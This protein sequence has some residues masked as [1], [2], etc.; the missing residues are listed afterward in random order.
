M[1][2]R[3]TQTTGMIVLFLFFFTILIILF[4]PVS[5]TKTMKLLAVSE[6]DNGYIGSTADLFLDVKPG[7]GRIFIDTYPLSKLDTQIST[8]FA[9]EIACKEIE[10]DCSEYDFFYT[11]KADT[12]IVGGPSAGSAISI[13]TIASMKNLELEKNIA[14]TGTIN[15]GGTIGPVGGLKEKIDAAVKANITK[16]LIPKGERIVRDDFAGNDSG[17]ATSTDLVEYAGKAGIEIVE[18]GELNEAV[19]LFSGRKIKPDFDSRPVVIDASYQNIMKNLAATLCS[20]TNDLFSEV[21]RYDIKND[22]VMAQKNMALNLSSRAN[23]SVIAGDYY[24]SASYCFGANVKLMYAIYFVQGIKED[25]ITKTK[26]NFADYLDNIDKSLNKTEIS[27]LTDLQTYIIVKQRILE[28]QD[29]LGIIDAVNSTGEKIYELAY[30]NER[31]LSAESWSRFFGA[32]GRKFDVDKDALKKSC[33]KKIDE[34]EER[35]QYVKLFFPFALEASRKDTANAKSD[36]NTGEYHLCLF[37]ASKAKAE[38]DLIISVLGVETSQIENILQMKEDIV[39]K[40]IIRNI[41]NGIFPILGYSYYEYAKS[42]KNSD[43]YS[44]LL[45]FEYAIELN[46]LDL[47]FKEEKKSSAKS[48][49][50]ELSNASKIWIALIAG[51]VIGIAAGIVLGRKNSIEIKSKKKTKK[52]SDK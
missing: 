2:R 51:I 37:K 4:P 52:K 41:D 32:P 40:N 42:L 27:T 38:A 10:E 16:V 31:I 19:Y 22:S 29:A 7:T 35:V 8:R 21:S 33:I 12:S 23:A 9:N 50:K 44:A 48:S 6:T 1:N 11:I 28:A 18:V 3:R 30:A 26:K 43:K 24:S 5:A 34:A 17:N 36:L 45:Y 46:N 47:Y 15:S 20:R 39:R 49:T 13:L 14:I 25:E